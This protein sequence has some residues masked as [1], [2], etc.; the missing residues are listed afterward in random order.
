MPFYLGAHYHVSL[1][2]LDQDPGMGSSYQ[3][4]ITNHKTNPR[5]YGEHHVHLYTLDEFHEAFECE[6]TSSGGKSHQRVA[7]LAIR[8]IGKSFFGDQLD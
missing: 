8:L 2:V 4:N 1:L 7:A 3:I 6:K 5:D